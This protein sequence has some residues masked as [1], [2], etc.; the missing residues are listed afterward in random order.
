MWKVPGFHCVVVVVMVG[1]GVIPCH[2]LPKG[3][4]SRVGWDRR[5]S[6]KAQR[7]GVLSVGLGEALLCAWHLL[8]AMPFLTSQDACG[9]EEPFGERRATPLGSCVHSQSLEAWALGLA[10]SEIA[11]LTGTLPRVLGNMRKREGARVWSPL[12]FF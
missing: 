7:A 3:P 10:W 4:V 12:S 11:V 1:G 5:G 9:C 2:L 8:T 6:Q